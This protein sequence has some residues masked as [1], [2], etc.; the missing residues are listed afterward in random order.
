MRNAYKIL[1]GKI[2]ASCHQ[3]SSPVTAAWRLLEL[4]KLAEKVFE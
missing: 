1:V 2:E 3:L 4:R